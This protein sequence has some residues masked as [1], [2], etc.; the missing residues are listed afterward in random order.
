MEAS[1]RYFIPIMEHKNLS[2]AFIEMFKSAIPLKEPFI[3]S[4]GSLSHAEN[5]I[6]VIHTGE[7]LT[8]YGECSPFPTIH[9]ETMN[10]CFAVGEIIAGR[11]I[12]KDPLNITSC[13]AA[14][15]ALI[16]GN[17]SIKSAFDM[18][19]FDIAAQY[20][21]LPLYAFLGGKKNKILYTDY[22]ISLGSAE[23]M[24]ADAARIV[25]NGFSV[26]KVKL[27]GS[28]EQDVERIGTIR[29]AIGMEIPLRIDANQGWEASTALNIL[30]ELS[31]YNIQHC[32]EPIPRWDF[33]AL[34]EIKK[35]SPIPIMADESCCDHHD[36]AR[37]IGLDACHAFNVKLGKS[38]GIVKALKIIAL[39]ESEGMA[40]QMGG[41][42][43]S[44]L[45]FTASAH[46]ALSSSNIIF[47][48]FDTPLMFDQDPVTGGIAYASGGNIKVPEV[49][50]IGA[51]FEPGYLQSL[52]KLHIAG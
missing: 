4:L 8:G 46:V 13:A 27:G 25:Q 18:A 16:Y 51:A 50:G 3:I 42:L 21:G 17:S 30:N 9:G 1:I 34:P 48:D 35:S 49:P 47:Y 41:F 24:A 20:A 38:A 7:G 5:V 28:Q 23:K 11:L 33:M 26:I 10:T 37:L 39:A 15:D 12:G 32:E 52:P 43:E 45:G 29:Q 31:R 2:I 36:A 14:M 6:V 19:L 44:R 22:T 40:M